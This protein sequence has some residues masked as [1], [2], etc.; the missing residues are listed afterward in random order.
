MKEQNDETDTHLIV[1]KEGGEEEFLDVTVD[2]S[3]GAGDLNARDDLKADT[4]R[5]NSKVKHALS[6]LDEPVYMIVHKGMPTNALKIGDKH[7]IF[8]FPEIYTI[9]FK[10]SNYRMDAGAQ[11]I[12]QD[13]LKAV[14]EVNKTVRNLFV[15]NRRHIRYDIFGTTLS[16]SGKPYTKHELSFD[17]GRTCLII[18]SNQI[19]YEHK[20]YL[21]DDETKQFVVDYM[22]KKKRKED[23]RENRRKAIRNW[24]W[25]HREDVFIA[26]FL[27]GV[28]TILIT[29]AKWAEDKEK[30]V[31]AKVDARKNECPECVKWEQAMQAYEDSL[32]RNTSGW[33]WRN[34]GK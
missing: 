31:K 1:D 28:V 3:A 19:L 23:K 33:P 16:D 18:E 8:V 29:L 20:F 11:K 30:S 24:W 4:E 5:V 22:A 12:V 15:R 2:E 27:C 17:A 14:S 21:M 7:P 25:H 10:K 34:K 9:R 26:L 32:L 6:V 13:Y